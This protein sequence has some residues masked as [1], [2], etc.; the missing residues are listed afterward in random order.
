MGQD[1]SENIYKYKSG[2]RIFLFSELSGERM[3]IL[4]WST[5]VFLLMVTNVYGNSR[6]QRYLEPFEEFKVRVFLEV[7]S[8]RVTTC[9]KTSTNIILI[10]DN[11][12]ESLQ[13]AY[14]GSS[15][16]QKFC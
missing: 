5:F 16:V 12:Q 7:L 1:F 4:W 8:N 13:Y 6:F 2:L 3:R 9:F 15:S 14:G 11:L 10:L